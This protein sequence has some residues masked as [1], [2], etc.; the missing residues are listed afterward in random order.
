[1]KG[2]DHGKTQAEARAQATS[3]LL[4]KN[5]RSFLKLLGIGAVA[6]PAVI[7]AAEVAIAS[8]VSLPLSASRITSGMVAA[9]QAMNNELSLDDYGNRVWVDWA[10]SA[11]RANPIR[12]VALSTFEV[13][14]PHFGPKS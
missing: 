8:D 10:K 6:A 9:A 4:M 2:H 7:Q 3:W 13:E 14:E 5:R 11:I 12:S 1:M